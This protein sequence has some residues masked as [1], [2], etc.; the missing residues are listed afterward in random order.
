MSYQTL[1]SREDSTYSHGDAY[2]IEPELVERFSISG[3][4]AEGAQV[5]QQLGGRPISC[6]G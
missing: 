3:D 2:L 1:T 4:T 5:H 6:R